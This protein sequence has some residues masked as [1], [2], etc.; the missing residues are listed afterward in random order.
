MEAE[1]Y[2]ALDAGADRPGQ[3]MKPERVVRDLNEL[4]APDA[5]IAADCGYNTGLTAPDV[6]MDISSASRSRHTGIDGRR[7][8][9]HDCGCARLPGSA[10]GRH[11][12][13]R[14]TCR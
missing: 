11:R 5:V 9:V 2:R 12:R 3:P 6:R 4:L 7:P 8:P 1:W 14:R 10:G 13:R